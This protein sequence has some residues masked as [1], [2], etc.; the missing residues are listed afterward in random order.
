MVKE[1]KAVFGIQGSDLRLS[2]SNGDE[3]APGTS[4]STLKGRSFAPTKKADQS[5]PPKIAVAKNGSCCGFVNVEDDK[6]KGC[7]LLQNP[8]DRDIAD[9]V[10]AVRAIFAV[11][12]AG[13]LNAAFNNKKS[14]I[15]GK[16]V[17]LNK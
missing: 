1:A 10:G 15:V 11:K 2:D 13:K 17:K 16:T 7:L 12:D 14:L 5:N 6:V 3:V 8:S 4:A 9:T